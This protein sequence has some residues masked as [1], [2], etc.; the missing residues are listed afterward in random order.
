MSAGAS[1]ISL[2]TKSEPNFTIFGV[3]YFVV[4][5]I[6]GWSSTKCLSFISKN[7]RYQV[8]DISYDKNI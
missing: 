7:R 3:V 6:L 2:I 5:A 4:L 1:I 8:S